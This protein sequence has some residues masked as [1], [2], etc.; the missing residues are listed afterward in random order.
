MD[1]DLPD[2]IPA[3]PAGRLRPGRISLVLTGLASVLISSMTAYAFDVEGL[4]QPQSIIVDPRTGVYYISNVNGDPQGKDHNG[5][6]S[7]LD[8]TGA[9][10]TRAFIDS[11]SGTPLHAPKGLAI[12]GDLLFVADIDHVKGYDKVTSRLRYDLDLTRFQA[13]ALHDLARDADGNLYVSDIE[14]NFIVKIEPVR[15]YAMSILIQGKQLGRP[16]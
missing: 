13:S 6:V 14:E 3:R 7:K 4:A 11:S 5:F 2:V 12:V 10:I 15:A 16:G 9:I 8:L 1:R